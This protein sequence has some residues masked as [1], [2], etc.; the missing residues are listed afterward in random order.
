MVWLF[1]D[2]R[3]GLRTIFKDRGFFLAAVLALA[4]GIGSTTAIFSVIDNVLLHPF[5][6][7]DSDRIFAI[8]IHDRA[9]SATEGREWFTVPEFLDYQQKNRIFDRTIGVL[10]ETVLLERSDT[11]EPF[12]ADTVTGN[13]FQFLGVSPLL[14][15]AILPTDAEHGAP[16]VFVLSY[17][18][19]AKKF[20]LDPNI[21]GKN[22]ILNGKPATLIGIMPPRFAF[23]GGDLWMP[24]SLDRA[25]PGA[26]NRMFVLYGHL[27]PALDAKAAAT[28]VATLAVQLSKIYPQNYSKQ[29]DVRLESLGHIAAGRVQ[30]TLFT[31]LAAVGFLLLIACA[32]VANLLLA[33]ATAREKELALR[34]ALGATRFRIVRQLMT[35]SVLLAVA[36][37]AVGC[38]LFA[39]AFLKGLVLLLPQFTFP[40]EAVI[41]LNIDV[42]VATVAVAVFTAMLFGLAPALAAARRDLNHP[43][44]AASRGNSGTGRGRLRNALIVSE[45]A[46]SLVLLTGSGLL[47]RSFLRERGIDLGIRT[48]HLLVTGLNLP[49]KRYPTT[50][51][52]M[53]FLRA[54]LPRLG[55][56]PGVVSA[57]VSL[58][59]PPLGGI[60]TEFDV[61][62]ATHAELWKGYMTPC[63]REYFQ[64][65][66]LRLISGRLLTEQDENSKRKVAVIN[67]TMAAKFFGRSDPIGRQIQLTALKSAPEPVARPWFE[68]A[69]VVSDVKNEGARRDAAPEAYVPY[70]V[71]GY[72]QYNV[73]IHTLADPAALETAFTKEV[74]NLDRNVIPQETQT[75][76]E[77]L[78]VSQYARP[79]FALMLFSVFA[80]IGLVLVSVGVYSVISYTV[81][82]QRHEIGIRMALGAGARDVGVLVL[83]SALRLIFIGLGIGELL[84]LLLSRFLASQIWG[85]SWYDPATH[86]GG[87]LILTLVGI[88]ASY[89]PSVRAMRVDPA[90]SLR[91][92]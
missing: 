49:A 78:E 34:I 80:S 44:K 60:G 4:L 72:G 76:D 1:Q 41:R 28:D 66:G 52:Q 3:F 2:I 8:Q 68:I 73:F 55:S 40:D 91:D 90:I 24:A 59:T 56:L 20:G 30:N 82:Q 48:D 75:M 54:L 83:R 35:E 12:D 17:K 23:W 84:G 19:W 47:M 37:A 88:A 50:D 39:S 74:L 92:E 9:D 45:V 43:M 79:R 71:A 46:L 5:P 77:L 87:I 65:V 25:E 6:Y 62:G 16:A 69:G 7:T 26:M 29:F 18:A 13:T 51:S 22:Y 42:L 58:E 53:R 85:V 11:P 21:V 57:A 81:T 14:G 61:M 64:T 27:K 33:K 86:A 63:S 32:N 36:G 89:V 67:R 70:T 31:L 10:E 15:R 38:L